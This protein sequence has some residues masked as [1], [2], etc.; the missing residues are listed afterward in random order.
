MKELNALGEVLATLYPTENLARV[1]V[2]EA[3]L[4]A[5]WIDFGGAAIEFWHSILTV[6]TNRGEM[7][8]LIDVARRHFPQNEA[9]LAAADAWQTAAA[10]AP[11]AE[12]PPPASARHIHIGGD[13]YGIVAGGDVTQAT[14]AP[15]PSRRQVRPPTTEE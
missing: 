11:N 5:A 8:P 14:V 12:E 2:S 10:S 4:P 13:N 3:G 6:A 15:P 9:L 7:Q 1:V